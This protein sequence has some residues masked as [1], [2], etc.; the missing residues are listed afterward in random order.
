MQINLIESP[1]PCEALNVCAICI[2]LCGR[3]VQSIRLGNNILDTQC[4]LLDNIR[5]ECN[6]YW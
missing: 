2:P 3:Y 5:N 4:N 6:K 1:A